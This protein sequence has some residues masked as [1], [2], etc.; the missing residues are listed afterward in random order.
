MDPAIRWL[1]RLKSAINM[2]LIKFLLDLSVKAMGILQA[3]PLD[4]SSTAE[5]IPV[6]V[7]ANLMIAAGWFI[8]KSLPKE[9]VV[10]NNTSGQINR[11]TWG[12]F[13]Q[14]A[15]YAYQVYPFEKSLFTLFNPTL[16]TNK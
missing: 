7:T 11:F 5:M 13:D 14:Y 16:T 3:M 15:Y 4:T 6:D 1:P 10:F 8:A 2:K 9:V 12:L